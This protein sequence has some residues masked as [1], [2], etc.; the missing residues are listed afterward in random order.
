MT[1]INAPSAIGPQA[2]EQGRLAA[3]QRYRRVMEHMG[4]HV[5][6]ISDVSGNLAAFVHKRPWIALVV[7]FTVGYLA[8]RIM[9][10][11]TA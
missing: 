7:T 11:V 8:A 5:D 6:A 4:K 1:D 3:D 10:R 2:V 9:P